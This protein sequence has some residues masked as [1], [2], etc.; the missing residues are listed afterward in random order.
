MEIGPQITVTI[1]PA[2]HQ[3]GLNTDT[4]KP[5]S[6][7]RLQILELKGDRALVDFGTF[8]AT[9]DIRVPV[10]LG[11]KLLVRVQET[12]RQL[13][14]NLINT[15]QIKSLAAD[16]AP[17]S[18]G[19]F[20]AED[21]RRILSD[22][23]PILNQTLASPDAANLPSKILDILVALNAHFEPFDLT[24]DIA[25][26]ASRLKAYLDNSGIFYEKLLERAVLESSGD[27]QTEALKQPTGVTDL[28]PLATED[29]KAGLMM[30]KDF[31]E[32][33]A[34]LLK[35]L[36]DKSVLALRRAAES[37]LEHID[38]Q[39]GR[40]V[41][42]LDGT[43]LFQVFHYTLPLKDD[44]QT[45]R[46]KIYYQKLPRAD[47]RKGFQISLLLSMNRLG[48]L[49]A[50]F[51][52]LEKDLTVTFFVKD[53]PAQTIFQRHV[54]ELQELLTPLFDQLFMR[55]MISEK[56]IKN[57]DREYVRTSGDRRVDLRI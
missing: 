29:L 24:A 10:T 4:F 51:S 6:I 39:Q 23:K 5:G 25:G 20:P 36:D 7:L 47:K 11:E 31:G 32:N 35:M 19:H 50:D 43:E 26:I 22:L 30:L 53:Q 41:K 15:E 34:Y 2:M 38:Q 8:K 49:R 46:L 37:L 48:D 45:A 17:R 42:Q 52:L 18:E 16:S 28:Q 9:A 33:D 21:I 1:N 14:L 56:K 55:V 13:K 27:V 54:C 44:N 3:A 12:G 57:F 40:A